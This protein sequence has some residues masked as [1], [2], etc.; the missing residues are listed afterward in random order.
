MA[1]FVRYAE[2]HMNP[3]S[4]NYHAT[5]QLLYSRGISTEKHSVMLENLAHYNAQLQQPLADE[6]ELM[7]LSAQRTPAEQRWVNKIQ[8]ELSKPYDDTQ[9]AGKM[10]A[11]ETD[12]KAL[13]C[14]KGGQFPSKLYVTG[15]ANKGRFG[16][17]SDLDM[18]AEGLLSDRSAGYLAAQPG[19]KVHNILDQQ[20]QTLRQEVSTPA[21][22]HVDFVMK[23]EF[24]QLSNWFG[25]HF[26][27]DVAKVQ[28]GQASGLQEAIQHGFEEKGYNVSWEGDALTLLGDGPTE[29]VQEKFTPYPFKL[30]EDDGYKVV[31]VAGQAPT[32]KE[33][34][35]DWLH[36]L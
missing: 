22:G 13:V 10:P 33:R 26:E 23:P 7:D 36:A 15:S 6:M 4:V 8:R 2:K 21:G 28:A 35:G 30:P 19:W 18:L 32:W 24:E 14:V 3:M 27:V 34:L 16:G 20:G 31:T 11:L 29:P 17:N 9:V 12:L 25:K 1:T 5:T